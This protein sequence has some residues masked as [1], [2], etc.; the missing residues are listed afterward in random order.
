MQ[1]G[2][3]E[4][5]SDG[6]GRRKPAAEADFNRRCADVLCI[7]H[8]CGRS[9][10]RRSRRCRDP[11]ARCLLRHA[12]LVPVRARLYLCGV[13]DGI[14]AGTPEEQVDAALR[15]EEMVFTAW[16]VACGAGDGP[17]RF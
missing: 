13:L 1:E 7:W 14:G 10:C 15:K 12:C 16:R 5:G 4:V 6:H 17:A 3:P 2:R 8:L 11:E 9:A